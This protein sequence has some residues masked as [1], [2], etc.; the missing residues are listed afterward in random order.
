MAAS[1]VSQLQPTSVWRYFAALS[2]IPRR[3]GHEEAVAAWIVSVAQAH[4]VP[5]VRDEVGNLVLQVAATAGREGVAPTV[6]QG[7]MDMV[8]EKNADTEHDFSRDP[9]RLQ[10]LGGEV[11]ATGTTLGADN[12]IGVAMA[13]ALLDTPQAPHGP[14]ELLFTVDEERGLTGAKALKPELLRGRRLINIDTEEQGQIYI[15]CAGGIDT[16]LE[17]PLQRVP[18]DPG[19]ARLSLTVKGL[20]G[21]HSGCDIHLGRGNANQILVRTLRMLQQE[22][23][24]VGLVALEGGSLRNAI[25]REATAIIDVVNTALVQEKVA[26]MLGAVQFELQG[27]DDGV[28][29]FTHPSQDPRLPLRA[30]DAARAVDLAMAIPHGALAY[31][32]AIDGLVE[33]SS[34][35]ATLRTAE[36]SLTIATSQRSSIGSQLQWIAESVASLG[37][38]AGARVEQSDGYPGWPPNPSSPLLAQ[39]QRVFE[40]HTGQRPLPKAIHAGLECG[41]IGDRFPGMDMISIGPDVRNA[42]SPDESVDIASVAETWKILLALLADLS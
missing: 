17:L 30:Q 9:I 42:H 18:R 20:R 35:L 32:R 33:T 16:V 13:L 2:A 24:V 34:N 8:C 10:V 1:T 22:D 11:K 26:E 39:A 25:P 19:A 14:L 21:G 38:L 40:L 31:S 5:Y 7:H 37:R 27:A 36:S 15:G 4:D 28:R 29:I 6:L 41:L 3:S 23:L 12:G